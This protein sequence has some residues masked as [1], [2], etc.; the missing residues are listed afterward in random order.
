MDVHVHKARQ[1]MIAAQ[2][3]HFFAVHGGQIRSDGR[4]AALVQAHPHIGQE[5]IIHRDDRVDHQHKSFLLQMYI[6]IISPMGKF[7]N[8]E[9]ESVHIRLKNLN[10]TL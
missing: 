2:V 5:C 4:N 8:Q 9:D 6:H 3:E 1:Q 7:F 10:Y